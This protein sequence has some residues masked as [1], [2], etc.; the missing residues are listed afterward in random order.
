VNCVH[1]Q[2]QTPHVFHADRLTPFFGT[3]T[4]AKKLGL[5]DKDEFI[6]DFIV[7]HRGSLDQRKQ[8]HFLVRWFGYD[9][10][11]DTWEPYANLRHAIPLHAY[12][13]RIDRID[14]IPESH[15]SSLPPNFHK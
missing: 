14:L 9:A 12:L 3:E 7:T 6:I 10:S 5:L 15:R 13:Q 2:L 1:C 8:L 11:S 4:A